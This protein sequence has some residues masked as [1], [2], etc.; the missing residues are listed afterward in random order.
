MP[1]APWKDLGWVVQWGPCSGQAAPCHRLPLKVCVRRGCGPTSRGRSR[2][3]RVSILF[4]PLVS[5]PPGRTTLQPGSPGRGGLL[6]RPS[7]AKACDRDRLC[8]HGWWPVGLIHNWPSPV[9][10]LAVRGPDQ[11]DS[12]GPGTG[13]PWWGSP[14]MLRAGPLPRQHQPAGQRPG[15]Q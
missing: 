9:P 8:Q 6:E 13:S 1:L 11:A 5:T 2:L 4:C 10:G 3:S 15:P 7:L 12:G 14:R